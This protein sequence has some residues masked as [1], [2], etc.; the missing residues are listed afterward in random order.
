MH[1]IQ[2]SEIWGGNEEINTEVRAGALTI[3]LYSKGTDG[4]RGGDIYYVSLCGK[5]M[6]TRIGIADV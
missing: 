4:E 5:E 1:T 3:S 2:C 6:L